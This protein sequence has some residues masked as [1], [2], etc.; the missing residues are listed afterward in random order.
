MI[1]QM[2]EFVTEKAQ[3]INRQVSRLRQGS[4]QSARSAAQG[5]ADFIKGL[6]TPVRVVAR[7]GIKLAAVSQTAVQELI[8]LQSD[9]LTSAI[10]EVALRLERASRAGN[11][12]E[13]VR[14]QVEMLPATRERIAGDT[15]RAMQ[16]FA[17]AGREARSV[18]T[19]TLDRVKE[20]A[21]KQAPARAVRRTAKKAARKTRTRSRKAAA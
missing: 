11:V 9:M 1:S 14:D 10:A 19:H 7:S 3:A 13:L 8:E 21:G 5:S 15:G 20:N 6:K 4:V 16:V 18:A 12:V 17:A 2:Q